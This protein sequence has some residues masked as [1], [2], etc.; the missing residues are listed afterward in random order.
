M[1]EIGPSAEQ[2]GD[3][4]VENTIVISHAISESPGLKDD[5][6]NKANV[7]DKSTDDDF[8]HNNIESECQNSS[9]PDDEGL[10][11][12]G[13]QISSDPPNPGHNGQRKIYV[14]SSTLFNSIL[15]RWI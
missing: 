5:C 7:F 14:L 9:K 13:D 8:K 12:D 4:S 15:L 6:V 11:C 2:Q 10:P 1:E 3:I